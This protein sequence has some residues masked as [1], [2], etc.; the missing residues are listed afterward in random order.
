MRKWSIVGNE[1]KR[2]IN[3]MICHFLDIFWEILG[4]FLGILTVCLHFESQLTVYTLQ[5]SWKKKFDME[6]SDLSPS[7]LHFQSQLIIYISKVS[8]LFWGFFGNFSRILREFFGNSLGIV[9]DCLYFQ[10]STCLLHFQSRLIVYI[11]KSAD[12]LVS[13]IDTI[14]ESGSFWI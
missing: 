6:G 2:L 14:L 13:W 4:N 12:V 7:L 9:T 10:K 1:D 11:S 8:W 3:K 5:I